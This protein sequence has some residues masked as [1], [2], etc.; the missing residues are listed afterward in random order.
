MNRLVRCV[1]CDE[2][3]LRTP[4]D[5]APEYE[6]ASPESPED[7]Q[8]VEQDDFEGFLAH[9]RGHRLEDLRIIE[10]SFVSEKPYWEPMKVSYFKATNGREKFVIR[11]FRERID[12]PLKYEL[13]SGD[14]SLHCTSLEMD[15]ENIARQMRCELGSVPLLEEKIGAFLKLCQ[16]ITSSLRLEDLERVAEDSPHPL[17]I[18]YR[19]DDVSLMY[20]LRNAR[21]LFKE[22]FSEVESFIHRHKDDGVLLVKGRFRIDLSEKTKTKPQELPSPIPVKKALEKKREI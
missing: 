10:D 22:R 19:L 7:F 5:Q 20:L 17:E 21:H 11:K 3:F 8:I 13:I 15:W 12:Q 2:V 6:Q 4:Y 14:Y 16:Q 9:H 1:N 18:S